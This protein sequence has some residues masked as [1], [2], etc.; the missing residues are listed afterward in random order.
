VD[1]GPL[2]R[3]TAREQAAWMSDVARVT[4]GQSWTEDG[5]R[6]VHNPA[7]SEVLLPFPRR[8]TPTAVAGVVDWARAAGCR[9][10]GCWLTGLEHTPALD[11]RL[12]AHGF[13]EGWRPHWM[14]L[15]LDA[16]APPSPDALVRETS[17]VP[18]WDP[19]GQALLALTRGARRRA[20][21]VAAREEDGQLAGFCWLHVRGGRGE[22]AGLFDLVVFDTFRGRGL[23]QALTAAACARAAA[24][25][26]RWVTLNATPAGE[27]VYAPM[28]SRSLGHGR[29]WWLHLCGG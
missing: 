10:A 14:A 20:W 12:A 7:A 27:R 15:D 13:E 28:G 25:G 18:E 6:R 8:A 29:T 22:V 1:A 9:T 17:E 3:A 21:L 26:C 24:L 5:L 23:G 4:G 16:A 2:I 19:Y 11:A